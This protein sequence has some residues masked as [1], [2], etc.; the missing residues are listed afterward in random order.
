MRC[1][2][3]PVRFL[4]WIL[5]RCLIPRLRK[6]GVSPTNLTV[7]GL[8]FCVLAGLAYLVSPL[9]AAMLAII[10][11][12]CDATDGLLARTLDATSSRGAFLDSVL[13]RYGE[14]CLMLGI[15]AYLSRFPAY[16]TIGTI[17]V[18]TAL[19][20]AF[21]VSYTRARGEG[22]AISF[23]R[24]LFT[25]EERLVLIILGSLLDAL[26]PG[27]I[28]LVTILVLAVGA[29]LTAIHRLMGISAQLSAADHSPL[30]PGNQGET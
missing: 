17:A 14:S 11:G 27:M 23:K 24:G 7:A 21:M 12:L 26:A 8:V 3:P 22:L 20:G 5:K 6:W 4:Y 15:W 13:D 28:L 16:G 25:R 18:L 9:W 1:D 10:G 30:S 29:N 19:I 2:L